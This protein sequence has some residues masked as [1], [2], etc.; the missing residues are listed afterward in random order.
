MAPIGKQ[1]AASLQCGFPVG[2][3]CVPCGGEGEVREFDSETAP[4]WEAQE[5]DTVRVAQDSGLEFSILRA[6]RC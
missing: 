2:A 3:A 4:A 1:W 6:G 5:C